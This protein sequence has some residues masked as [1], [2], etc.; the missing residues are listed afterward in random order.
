M[1]APRKWTVGGKGHYSSNSEG[2]LEK[3]H[4]VWVQR[5]GQPKLAVSSLDADVAAEDAALI[6][7]APELLA[8]S[9]V[10]MRLDTDEG[11]DANGLWMLKELA[12]KAIAKAE[13]KPPFKFCRVSTAARLD[14]LEREI[15]EL[16]QAR[17]AAT[18]KGRC[19][20]CKTLVERPESEWTVYSAFYIA[21]SIICPR[22]GST[23]HGAHR[24]TPKGGARL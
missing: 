20:S 23:V 7:A 18:I 15:A 16:Q 19:D 13:G 9:A 5:E 6:A 21:P 14:R 10:I 12:A 3:G 22:C 24:I 2:P 17:P 4:A 1:S 11:L 8:V